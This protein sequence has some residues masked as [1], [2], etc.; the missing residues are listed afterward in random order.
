MTEPLA[1]LLLDHG[2]DA[3]ATLQIADGDSVTIVP[4]TKQLPDEVARPL[5]TSIAD[6]DPWK[7]Y[8]FDPAVIMRFCAPAEASAPRYLVTRKNEILG[9]FALKNGW[10][11]GSYLHILAI[12][13]A[14]HGHG[15][16]SAV[17]RWIEERARANGERNQFVVTS[18]F[19]TRGL[20]LYQ[21]HGY[22][23]IATM[24]GLINDS[25]SEILLRKRLV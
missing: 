24:P 19:N 10:M 18:A 15:I 2:L 6:M 16:G 17:L 7:R 4:I 12:L 23:P 9:L 21:R 14:G 22:E 25:E 8:Q 3:I 13:P 5:A 11:F 1:P 20:A